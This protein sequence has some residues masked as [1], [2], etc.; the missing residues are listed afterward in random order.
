MTHEGPT[1][2]LLTRQNTP[3]LTSEKNT[4]SIAKGAYII[5]EASK[6][7]ALTIIA[8]GSE[9]SIACQAAEQIE[10][11]MN[12][13]VRV[14]SM[15]CM[16]VFERQSNDYKN[17]VIDPALPSISIEAGSTFGWSKWADFSIGIDSFGVSAPGDV[18]LDEFGITVESVINA[19]RSIIPEEAE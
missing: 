18:A 15:P 3:V 10:D 7:P 19:A 14:V 17:S 11:S 1:A 16:E 4:H 12:S 2:M 9:V 5:Y 8:T 13:G 6:D